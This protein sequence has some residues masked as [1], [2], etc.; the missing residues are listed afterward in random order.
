MLKLL[1]LSVAIASENLWRFVISTLAIA[2]SAAT[3]LWMA[4]TYNA[5]FQ[6]FDD[7][8]NL[9]FGKHH[10]AVAPIDYE[11]ELAISEDVVTALRADERVAI[12]ETYWSESIARIDLRIPRTN[13]SN[14]THSGVNDEPRGQLNYLF[15]TTTSVDP[16][17]P[18]VRGKWIQSANTS[19]SH[20]VVVRDDV[21]QRWGVDL[22]DRIFVKRSKSEVELE[23][24]GIV[25][26]TLLKGSASASIHSLTPNQAECFIPYETAKILFT[27]EPRISLIGV[28]VAEGQDI[29]T[30]RFDWAHQLSRYET[31]VQ[32]Q[33]A[34]E[35]EEQLDQSATA[36]SI[37]IQSYVAIAFS[38]LLTAI[39]TLWGSNLGVESKIQQLGML[40]A[41]G[42]TRGQVASVPAIEAAVRGVVAWG[43]SMFLAVF[44]QTLPA[45]SR[46]SVFKHGLSVE[47]GLWSAGAIAMGAII[48]I[49]SQLRVALK[50][51]P[52]N[53][54]AVSG[55]SALESINAPAPTNASRLHRYRKHLVAGILSM[56]A[57]CVAIAV[58]S[59]L[60]LGLNETATAAII[61]TAIIVAFV[62]SALACYIPF[63][64][65]WLNSI[66]RF[67][68]DQ[69]LMLKQQIMHVG[70]RKPIVPIALSSCLTLFL[71]IH[72]WGAT[73]MEAFVPGGWLP[74]AVAHRKEGFTPAQLDAF[75]NLPLVRDSQTL[76][77]YVE[78]ARLAED[79]L[80]SKER[81]TVTRQDN[82]LVLGMAPDA[83]WFGHDPLLD[84]NWTAGDK[85]L[86]LE[87]LKHE[88][89][90]IVVDHFLS[91]SGLKIGDKIRLIP[92]R[93]KTTEPVE[94]IIAGAVE[95]PGWHWQTKH[96]NMRTRSH[97]TAA[98]IFIDDSLAKED[99][100]HQT[101][102]HIW[103]DHQGSVDNL[104]PGNEELA[105]Q[106]GEIDAINIVSAES[107]RDRVRQTSRRWL[108]I[109]SI[110]PIIGL[111]IAT[112]SFIQMQIASLRSRS[113]ELGV[114]RALGFQKS[115]V[116]RTWV[117]EIAL[118]L[119][120]SLC[121]SFLFGWLVSYCAVHFTQQ[122]SFFG[123]VQTPMQWP[124][125]IFVWCI[126]FAAVILF[127]GGFA[128]ARVLLRKM[129]MHLLNASVAFGRG[130]G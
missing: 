71:A 113:W 19:A 38:A 22:G 101:F 77:V 65:F 85:K 96:T 67:A 5:I 94:Y 70:M 127:L 102:T 74:D 112:L 10:L 16:P 73:L 8:A 121:H 21:A 92:P 116:I 58:A 82:V 122:F 107:I 126:L 40:R 64:N 32:F 11:S 59:T 44:A 86:S 14:R 128:P 125:S 78:Q 119:L 37:K 111:A 110:V 9:A 75:Q 2:A 13:A 49:I 72:L 90:C 93:R 106:L 89:G 109:I 30:F 48:A 57:I 50:V 31:P 103:F 130:R 29:H 47:G 105:S 87:Q 39:A 23:V 4:S 79:L 84:V 117:L 97:R 54:I 114:V 24:V 42:F 99:Y 43:L 27:T 69:S 25:S 129:P 51:H 60:S 53:A 20:S 98:M 100:D 83:T 28:Q 3:V 115:E 118:I 91:E 124:I 68:P 81:S 26:A 1:R 63:W 18:L 6:S 33:H 15:M 66:D 52:L 62:A 41:L 45:L 61:A 55:A 108:W 120:F 88:R 17:H 104:L 76:G 34:Y 35:L 7:Y 123:G 12:A 80:G 46:V 95:L 36:R 56:V